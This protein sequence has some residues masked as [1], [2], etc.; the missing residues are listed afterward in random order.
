VR[1][2][3]CDVAPRWRGHWAGMAFMGVICVGCVGREEKERRLGFE[4]GSPYAF[5]CEFFFMVFLDS[6]L[7]DQAVSFE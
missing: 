5:F 7:I 2:V 4:F 1:E 3:E 6:A